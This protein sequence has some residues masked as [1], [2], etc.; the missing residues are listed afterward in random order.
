MEQPRKHGTRV[1][2][3]SESAVCNFLANKGAW[4]V[5][6]NDLVTLGLFMNGRNKGYCFEGAGVHLPILWRAD[7]AQ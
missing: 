1:G 5:L 2:N 6:A 4:E 7:P 3:L